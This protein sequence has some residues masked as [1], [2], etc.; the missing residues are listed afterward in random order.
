[1][2]KTPR[3]ISVAS[4][5]GTNRKLGGA[6]KPRALAKTHLEGLLLFSKNE[7][8]SD[9]AENIKA[10]PGQDAAFL[11]STPSISTASWR[12]GMGGR[13]HVHMDRGLCGIGSEVVV[14]RL[15]WAMYNETYIRDMCL[16]DVK[17]RDYTTGDHGRM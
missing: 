4:P 13:G 3:G 7:A 1:M 16:N 2:A 17:I 15:A 6:C 11:P 8:Q 5:E 10:G 12:W 14:C 9:I